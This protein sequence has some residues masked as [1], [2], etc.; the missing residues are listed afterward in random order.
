MFADDIEIENSC[1]PDYY[2]EPEKNLNDELMTYF[3]TNKLSLNIPKC[4]F[5]PIGKYQSF[6][7]MPKLI[8]KSIMDFYEKKLLPNILE[9]SMMKI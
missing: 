6:A 8:F 2:L 1:K 9:C 5:L 7:K 3:D 4:E